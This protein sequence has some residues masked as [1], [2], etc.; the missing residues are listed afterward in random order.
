VL[1]AESMP[2]VD[3]TAVKML[4]EVSDEL[5]R[6][7]VKLLIARDVGQVRDVVRGA[8]EGPSLRLYPTVQAAI[9]SLSTTAG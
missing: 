5:E 9:E 4:A 7:G 3:V 8:G 6:R 1:D 2:F